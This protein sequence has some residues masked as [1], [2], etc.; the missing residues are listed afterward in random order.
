M[1]DGKRT[2]KGIGGIH[3]V[4]IKEIASVGSPVD[5]GSRT[6]GADTGGRALRHADRHGSGCQLQQ[7]N[8]LPSVEGEIHGFLR[9]DHGAK[10]G[11]AGFEQGC[12]VRDVDALLLGADGQR[13]RPVR[14]LSDLQSQCRVAD[15]GEAGVRNGDAIGPRL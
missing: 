11:R 7:L 15:C 3:P 8:K 9:T 5:R 6:A 13:H 12:R 2:K 1:A 10:R 14:Y 4:N